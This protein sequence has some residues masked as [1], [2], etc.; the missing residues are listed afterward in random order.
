[1]VENRRIYLDEDTLLMI[2]V[3]GGDRD[4]Y[5]EL[6]NKYFPAVVGFTISLNGQ[7]QSSEDVAQEVF[8]RIW[9]K[10]KEYRPT[11]AFK[12][13]LFGY[14]RN[15]V[16]ELQQ[17]LPAAANHFEM[18]VEPSDPAAMVQHKELTLLIERAKSK[19]SD[20]QLQALEFTFYSNMPIDEAA[21]LVGCSSRVFRQRIYDAKKRL[22]ALFQYI[23]KY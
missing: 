1:V 17:H 8:Y 11:A 4:A 23:R 14:A 18:M 7:L 9:E 3:S 2:K 15:V 19:L 21:K 13:F 6:Y 20:K 12:T 22:S 10:R 16:H 5:K